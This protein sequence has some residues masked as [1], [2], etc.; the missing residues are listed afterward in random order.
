IKTGD[1]LILDGR[2]G[3]V[4]LHPTEEEKRRYLEIDFQVREWEQELLLLAH[5]ESQTQ[6]GVQIALR[7]NIDLPGGA[8]PACDH[9]AEGIGLFRTEFLVVGRD[10]FPT[11]EEQVAAS[12]EVLQAFPSAPVIIRT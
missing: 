12:R 11:E 7:A 4:I 1:E 10:S 6:D 3:R 5:L 2:T 8:Q 9:G